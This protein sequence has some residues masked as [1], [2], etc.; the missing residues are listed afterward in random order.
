MGTTTWSGPI[1]SLNGSPTVTHTIPVYGD[2]GTVYYIM[3]STT[4]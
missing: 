3:A 4:A 1:Q 2:D